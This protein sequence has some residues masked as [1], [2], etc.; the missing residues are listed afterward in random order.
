MTPAEA[1]VVLCAAPE[2][3]DAKELAEA[4]LEESLAACVQVTPGVTSHYRWNGAIETSGEK[5]LLIKT[6]LDLFDKVEA[7][8][9]S[10]H[11]YDVP[12]IIALS[13]SAGHAPYLA[14]IAAETA[15]AEVSGRDSPAE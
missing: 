13:V 14:W 1:I 10:R 12:E 3:F 8:I 5:L 11:P 6:R 2:D 7:A 9:R 4:L 15:S